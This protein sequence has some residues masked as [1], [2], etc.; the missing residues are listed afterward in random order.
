[1]QLIKYVL[2]LFLFLSINSLIFG[3]INYSFKTI[4]N[5]ANTTYIDSIKKSK[6]NTVIFFCP[7]NEIDSNIFFKKGKEL[8]SNKKISSFQSI[9]IHFILFKEDP[10]NNSKGIL[11][12][13]NDKKSSMPIGQLE[14]FFLNFDKNLV[15]RARSKDKFNF[16]YTQPFLNENLYR[17]Q[18]V[19]TNKCFKEIPDRIPF[20]AD[21]IKEAY[22]PSYTL[23]EKIDF[24]NDS[25]R[26]MQKKIVELS[27]NNDLIIS[28]LDSLLNQYNVVPT[29]NN[30]KGSSNLSI[31]KSEKNKTPKNKEEE[32]KSKPANST[33]STNQEK[34]KEEGNKSNK[35]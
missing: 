33:N 18:I 22:S 31:E 34:P 19:D 23:E 30:K 25:I 26:T 29:K 17:I 4:T 24:L 32:K 14:C 7:T 13:S 20:Y 15:Q 10:K 6:D 8:V 35:N 1:M 5:N 12:S 11:F 21:F 9:K 16:E 3:Q 2:I 27:L 28:K